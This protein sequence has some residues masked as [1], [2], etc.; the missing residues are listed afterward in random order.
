MIYNGET[1]YG[2]IDYNIRMLLENDSGIFRSSSHII[3]TRLDSIS[4]IANSHIPN[5]IKQAGFHCRSL[6]MSIVVLSDEI[7][8]MHKHLN[9]F[10]GFDEM[11]LCGEKPSAKIYEEISILPPILLPEDV[12]CKKIEDWMD[13]NHCHGGF[14]DGDGLNFVCR[15]NDLLAFLQNIALKIDD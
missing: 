13:K 3:V 15:S 8:Q 6:G 5:L 4:K 12:P 7:A 1:I 9:L 10:T 2:H 11:W 14:A